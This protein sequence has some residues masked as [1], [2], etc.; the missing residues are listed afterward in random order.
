MIKAIRCDQSAFR[1][2]HLS[3]GMNVILADRTHQESTQDSRNGLGKSSLIEV[4]H[5]CLGSKLRESGLTSPELRGWT[6]TLD[7]ELGGESISIS[8]NTELPQVVSVRGDMTDWQGGRQL[9]PLGESQLSIDELNKFLGQRV[10]GISPNPS[11]K[12]HPRFR[13]IISY[14]I[15][16]GK[17]YHSPFDHHRRQT[18]VDTQVANAFLLGLSFKHASDFQLLKDQKNDLSQLKKSSSSGSLGGILGSMGELQAL[19]VRL[20]KKAEEQSKRLRDFQVH[21][22]YNEIAHKADQ[23]TTEIQKAAKNK[24]VNLRLLRLYTDKSDVEHLQVSTE[25]DVVEMYRSS[26]VE[27][28]EMV[29]NQLESVKKF[30]LEVVKNRRSFLR[31]EIAKIELLIKRFDT[32]LKARTA[33][34]ASLM[35]ILNSHGALEEYNRI[36]RLHGKTVTDLNETRRKIDL[37]EQIES[38]R[39][40]LRVDREQLLVR[41][42]RD[43]NERRAVYSQA[44]ELFNAN[45]QLLYE[46]P[47][48]L[49]IDIDENGFRF[50]VEIERSASQ[51]V[52]NM[53]IFCYD[54]MLA[55]LWSERVPSFGSLIHDST[56][57]DGVDE[58]QIATAIQ[59]ASRESKERKFQYVCMMNSDSLP[60]RDLAPD[61]N[62]D[63][64]VRLRLNDEDISGCLF[65]VRF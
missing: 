43:M 42:R 59:M 28:P 56:V 57:F 49:V 50:N 38:K 63:D 37:L 29:V 47:G 18:A 61:F 39:S 23:L 5:F 55:Q 17:S 62:I 10:L 53:K 36:Q 7:L 24:S 51:G 13:N 19:S 31:E 27:V 30:H 40:A 45:S 65:G 41:S 15:R 48:N 35:E 46:A 21:E 26:G 54:L 14:F 64:F 60:K 22:D 1:T 12:Y 2:V 44:I 9:L 58:R 6:F 11:T 25:A 16:R 52:E 32:E 20:E 4:I 8:R 34:R 3:P 33:E